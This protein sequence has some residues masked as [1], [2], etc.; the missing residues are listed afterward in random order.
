MP[1]LAEI[2]DFSVL[3]LL[4]KAG[5]SGNDRLPG[6][7]VT[8]LIRGLG[9][10]LEIKPF[11]KSG[12]NK[13][14][15]LALSGDNYSEIGFLWEHALEI[16]LKDK[17]GIRPGQI[18]LDGVLGSPDGFGVTPFGPCVEEYKVT[19][20]SMKNEITSEWRYMMQVKAYCKMLGVTLALFR[21]LYVNGN[22]NPMCPQNR[23]YLVQFTQD[24][25]DTAW[26]MLLAWGH[27]AGLFRKG[28]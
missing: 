5:G 2:E 23:T 3:Q 9:T 27:R 16:A 7:H 26:D 22:Y 11:K 12:S 19:W 18:E 20:R 15:L 14:D 1:E 28:N 13:V 6:V 21:V 24:E 10:E 4:Q 17:L 8:D 25:I